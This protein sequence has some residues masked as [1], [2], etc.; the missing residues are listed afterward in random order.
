[1][2]ELFELGILSESATGV[3]IPSGIEWISKFPGSRSI[4]D[5]E[6]GFRRRV[7][8][9]IYALKQAGAE[10]RISSTIRSP[11]HAYLMH[12]SW[13]IVKQNYDPRLIP[14]MKNVNISWWHGDII[15]SKKAA[16]EIVTGFGIDHLKVPPALRSRHTE[17]KAIDMNISWR[18]TLIIKGFDQ[19]KRVINSAPRDGTNPDL[20]N[21][22]RT[23]GVIHFKNVLKDKPHWSTDGR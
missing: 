16:Q 6:L 23:Y 9:F 18:G 21:V 14:P 3:I 5:L 22:G 13:K 20:I 2:N 1:L 17:R 10:V 4:D 19:A 15:K 11:E 12:W 8:R 7:K